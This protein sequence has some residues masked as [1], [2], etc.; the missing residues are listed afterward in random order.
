MAQDLEQEL[1]RRLSLIQQREKEL[2]NVVN[3][4]ATKQKKSK[5]L[6]HPQLQSD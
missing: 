4:L 5:T 2:A 3:Q 1:S 6:H